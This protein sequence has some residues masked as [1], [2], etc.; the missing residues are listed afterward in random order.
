MPVWCLGN[1]PRSGRSAARWRGRHNE[2]SPFSSFKLSFSVASQPLR[3]NF[4]SISSLSTK[5]PSRLERTSNHL[6]KA[7]VLLR[8]ALHRRV[9]LFT[10][11]NPVRSLLDAGGA[12]SR[13]VSVR[14]NPPVRNLLTMFRQVP[15]ETRRDG[16]CWGADARQP[17]DPDPT[18]YQLPRLRRTEFGHWP[19]RVPTACH[20]IRTSARNASAAQGRFRPTWTAVTCAR[21]PGEGHMTGPIEAGHHCAPVASR[22]HGTIEET[23]LRR[24]S[25]R[26]SP[27]RVPRGAGCNIT[28]LDSLERANCIEAIAAFEAHGKGQRPGAWRGQGTWPLT[29]ALLGA[30]TCD[31]SGRP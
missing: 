19:A 30:I 9:L 7:L 13:Y 23:R 27:H 14:A 10:R 2:A 18:K 1:S 8:S 16:L 4:F 26:E 22:R 17:G 11:T 21:C 3:L 31:P 29:L 6:R 28:G 5:P 15:K 20:D 24:A 12:R 25:H